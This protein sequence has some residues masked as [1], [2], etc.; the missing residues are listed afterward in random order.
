MHFPLLVIAAE[1]DDLDALLW[2]YC[3]N[4]DDHGYCEFEENDE[5]DVDPETGRRGYWWNPDT[6]WDWWEIG[7]RWPNQLVL[8]DGTRANRA[9]IVDLDLDALRERSFHTFA[10][11]E[12]GFWGQVGGWDFLSE[13]PKAEHRSFVDDHL[14]RAN[15]S[16]FATVIDCHI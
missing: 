2:P 1:H 14:A 3:Q 4:N 10:V 7:G 16:L 8:K 9:R 12:D 11:M 13:E 6:E 15:P 5:F